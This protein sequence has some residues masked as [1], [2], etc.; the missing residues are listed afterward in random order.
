MSIKGT[1]KLNY[2]FSIYFENSGD[3]SLIKIYL[4]TAR[5]ISVDNI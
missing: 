1:A 4:N 3:A 5:V 2:F